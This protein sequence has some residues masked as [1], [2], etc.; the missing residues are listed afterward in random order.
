MSFGMANSEIPPLEYDY[1]DIVNNLEHNQGWGHSY[2]TT[3]IPFT[4][5]EKREFLLSEWCFD[6]YN[7]RFQHIKV[8]CVQ[9]II[10]VNIKPLENRIIELE[11]NQ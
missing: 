2:R 11:K 7:S 1:P 6:D 4:D 8:E 9:L 3:P 5:E 10:D